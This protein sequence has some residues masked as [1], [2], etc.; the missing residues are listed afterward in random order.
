[1]YRL[2]NPVM[3][4]AWGSKSAIAALQGRQSSAL[5]EAELWMGAHPQAPSALRIGGELAPLG[6]ALAQAAA[7]LLGEACATAFDGQLPFLFKVLAAAE[8]L[9]IQAHP[10]LEQ[11]RAGFAREETS[12]VPRGDATRTYRDANHKP[13]LLCAL[14]EFHA[15][16]GFRDAAELSA[17]FDQLELRQSPAL[18]ALLGEVQSDRQA[19][20]RSLVSQILS[21]PAIC[22]AALPVLLRAA[23][24]RG[25]SSDFA[26]TCTWITRLNE[27]Y[28]GDPGVLLS[29]FLNY[30]KLEPEEA[31][32]LPAGVP[33]A[34]LEGTGVELMANSDNV[35]RGGLTSKHIDVPELLNILD[36]SN[37][38]VQVLRPMGAPLTR[39]VTPADEFELW[40]LDVKDEAYPLPEARGPQIVLCVEGR[41]TLSTAQAELALDLAT[42]ESVFITGGAKSVAIAGHGKAYRAGLPL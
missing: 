19:G 32:Y 15:L 10:N 34:Y 11:A 26:P 8:P 37:S 38:D 31:I 14:T 23:A 17:V 29:L 36:C 20:T 2:Q 18:K 22:A 13:E 28:P 3:N 5:P 30:V 16:C 35:I 4:Y 41:I 39:Y 27:K 7:P 40:R 25:P 12:A 6:E 24:T 42:G 33:H 9:S 1:M 21:D